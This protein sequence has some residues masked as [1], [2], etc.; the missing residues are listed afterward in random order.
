MLK[1]IFIGMVL[2]TAALTTFAQET[3]GTL[4]TQVTESKDQFAEYVMRGWGVG[5]EYSAMSYESQIKYNSAYNRSN[6]NSAAGAVGLSVNYA[7]LPRSNFGWIAGGSIIQKTENEMDAD[8][9][10]RSAKSFTQVRPELSLAYAL[11]NGIWG[12]VGGHLSVLSGN[13]I[14]DIVSPL[15]VGVQVA[16]GIT[17]VKNFS[18]DIGLYSTQHTISQ[19]LVNR[20]DPNK[21]DES[22]TWVRINQARIRTT[23]YF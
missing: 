2:F 13:N 10:L 22:E 17:P 7:K 8:Y 1:Q 12:M 6:S 16:A 20:L 9:S 19:T 23:Y 11:A 4:S 14:N 5:F 21:L 3:Q 15:G 18:V